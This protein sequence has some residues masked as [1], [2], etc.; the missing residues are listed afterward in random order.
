MR[1][2]FRVGR[3]FGIDIF[4][5]WSWLLIFLLV[6][7]NLLAMFGSLHPDWG[8]GLS[9]AVAVG[10]SLLFFASV[11][12]H[13]MAH[14]L[15]ARAQ[16]V[17]V[18]N[19]VL[20]LFGGVSNIE[21]EPPSPRAEFLITIVGPITSVLLGFLFIGAAI[22]L[23]GPVEPGI[24]ADPAQLIA[25][26]DPLTTLLFWLGPINILLGIFNMIPGFPLDGG[27][28]LRSILWAVTDDLRRATRWASR[29]G[30]LVAWL[31]IFTGIA[32]V[33]GIQV[34]IFGTGLIG[35][36]WLAFIGWF[37]NSAAIQSYQQVVI[38]DVLEGVRVERMMRSSPPTV[39]PHT[40]VEKLVYDDLMGTDEHAF[41]VQ[42]D[43]RLVGLVT[44]EDIRK[45]PRPEWPQVQ[46][47]QI[48]T[49][50]EELLVVQP[51]ED[52]ADAL[53]KLSQRDVRQ[54]PVMRNGDMVGLLR[55]RDITRWLQFHAEYSER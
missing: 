32:M 18:R 21:R 36:L 47:A 31:L 38:R 8:L 24:M 26:L 50:A 51:D 34:P 33:F 9:L 37:L 16:G 19:I 22:A 55:R 12:A 48:M 23:I 5:D 42:E 45:V 53:Q 30:Q 35:G 6:T 20:F 27:R 4:I 1:S 7:W 2:G 17:P 41:P 29:V 3:L 28:I 10:A 52:A 39:S 11:L 40:S 54:L 25:R 43:G 49:P 15:M 44:L 46:V 14:S 13:E